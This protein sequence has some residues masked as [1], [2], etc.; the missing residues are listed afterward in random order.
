MRSFLFGLLFEKNTRIVGVTTECVDGTDLCVDGATCE[1]SAQYDGYTCLCPAGKIGNGF[2]PGFGG[3]GC[4]DTCDMFSVDCSN[5]FFELTLDKTCSGSYSFLKA[6]NFYVGEL[7]NSG[8]VQT[9]CDFADYDSDT[10]KALVLFDRCN[11]NIQIVGNWIFYSNEISYKSDIDGLNFFRPFSVTCKVTTVGSTGS[12]TLET[13]SETSIIGEIEDEIIFHEFVALEV[14]NRPAGAVKEFRLGERVEIGLDFDD[15]DANFDFVINKCWAF[16]DSQPDFFL[17]G[18]TDDATNGCPN[19]DWVTLNDQQTTIPTGF[20]R[21]NSISFPVFTFADE[22][23]LNINCQIFV[24]GADSPSCNIDVS[25][26]FAEDLPD[27]LISGPLPD[28]GRRRR[29]SLVADGSSHKT[30]VGTSLKVDLTKRA[31]LG[32][33]VFQQNEVKVKEDNSAVLELL[34]HLINKL[35]GTSSASAKNNVSICL[36][37]IN[38]AL[39]LSEF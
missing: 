16:S 13:A 4:T 8:A 24:C 30:V 33:K 25:S 34:Q 18:A 12:I 38:V 22:D 14:I 2:E 7:D 28:L 35:S 5:A 19:Y 9:G 3:D 20:T 37:L 17:V 26:C 31:S 1:Q 39:L 11:T 23:A 6:E 36:F 21:P 15:L 32:Q 29:R 10:R 27:L